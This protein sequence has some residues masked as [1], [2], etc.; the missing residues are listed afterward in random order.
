MEVHF[1]V[2]KEDRE[3]FLENLVKY[4]NL[5]LAEWILNFIGAFI[6]FL[7]LGYLLFVRLKLNTHVAIP[8]EWNFSDILFALVAFYGINGKLPYVLIQKLPDSL[9]KLLGK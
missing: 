5:R 7:C 6:G 3:K 2:K 9:S 1:G 4:P 8:Q